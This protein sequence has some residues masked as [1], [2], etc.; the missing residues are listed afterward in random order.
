M[1]MRRTMSGEEEEERRGGGQEVEYAADEDHEKRYY[2]TERAI[3]RALKETRPTTNA[4]GEAHTSVWACP[5][6]AT[7]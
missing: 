1:R 4:R 7:S 3:R 2:L 6:C 5:V